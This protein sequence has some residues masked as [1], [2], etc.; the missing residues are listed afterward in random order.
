MFSNNA[1]KRHGCYRL[2]SDQYFNIPLDKSLLGCLDD[3]NS[4]DHFDPTADSR[5][6]FAHFLYLRTVYSSLQDGFNLVQRG[7]WTYHIQY[8]GSN[9]TP[10]EMGLFSVSRSGIS[11]IQNLTGNFSD[12]IWMLY[13]NENVTQNFQF[14]CKSP[15]WIS[16]PYVSGT[17]VRNLVSPF[18]NYT[19]ADSLSS[20]NNNSQAPYQ[21][22]L[23]SVTMDPYGFKVLVPATDWVPPR[24][25]LTKFSPGHDA[26][27]SSN[28]GNTTVTVSF[29]FNTVMSCTGVTQAL[30]F[31]MSSSGQGGNPTFDPNS[32]TCGQVKNP[33]PTTLTGDVQSVW[34]WSVALQNVPDGILELTLKNAPAGD[35]RTTGVWLTSQNQ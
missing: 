18:E 30:S 9:G 32:V 19:L 27:I 24:P 3:W 6:M 25:A 17:T 35:G 2:G 29:E 12:Q 33:D 31:N 8:P 13:S 5:R 11:G 4:L 15:Q 34:S 20:F 22:C 21:G 26:R 16:S 1:W 28:G 23:S 7:N 14:D 10:T